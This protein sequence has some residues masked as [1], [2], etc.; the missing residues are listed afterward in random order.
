MIEEEKGETNTADAARAGS[1]GDKEPPPYVPNWQQ[2]NTNSNLAL[3]EEKLE[4]LLNCVPPGLNEGCDMLRAGSVIE[5]GV[6][7]ALFVMRSVDRG[8]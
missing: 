8:M 5:L 4:W 2:V 7:S 6:Q 1:E 3:A